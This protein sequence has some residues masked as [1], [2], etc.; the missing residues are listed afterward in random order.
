[1]SPM[2]KSA[3]VLVSALLLTLTGGCA[4]SPTSSSTSAARANTAV[5]PTPQLDRVDQI[6]IPLVQTEP[7]YP[8]ELRK[9]GITG[10][11]VV[12]F[13]VDTKGNVHDVRVIQATHEE[14]GMAAVA[15]VSK[16]K[17]KPGVRGGRTVN[18]LLSVPIY[19]DLSKAAEKPSTTAGKPESP[20]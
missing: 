16:W 20:P 19:F 8:Y 10:S 5:E 18:T 17:F 9:K 7:I 1:M 13:I 15:C 14:F 3:P 12:G 2:E 6:P 4:T 11:A